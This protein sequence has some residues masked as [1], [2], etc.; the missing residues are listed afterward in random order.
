MVKN[1]LFNIAIIKDD[2]SIFHYICKKEIVNH[3]E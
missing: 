1:K 3:N 2:S